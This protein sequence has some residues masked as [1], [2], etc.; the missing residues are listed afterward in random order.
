MA[1]EVRVLNKGDTGTDATGLGMVRYEWY[2]KS[3]VQRY[4]MQCSLKSFPT[5][6]IRKR[7]IYNIV[8]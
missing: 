1:P 6:V 4:S 5:A 3:T 8:L 2:I 7:N